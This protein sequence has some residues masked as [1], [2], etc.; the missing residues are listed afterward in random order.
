MKKIA[1]YGKGGIGKSTISTNIAAALAEMGYK[2][3]V[4]GCDPKTDCTRNLHGNRLIKP[5]LDYMRELGTSEI[6]T[7]TEILTGK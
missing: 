2:V 5:L 7:T 1:L 6:E 4:I 3:M